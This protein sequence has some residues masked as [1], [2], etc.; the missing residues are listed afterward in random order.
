MKFFDNFKIFLTLLF[1]T[2]NSYSMSFAINKNYL[3]YNLIYASG[4]IRSGDLNRLKNIYYSLNRTKQT[5]VI[6]NSSGG[7]LYEGLNIGRFIKSNHIG[8]AVRK[9][10]ICASSCALAFFAG[11][12]KNGNRLNILPYTSYLGLHSFYYK[13]GKYVK[14]TKVQQDLSNILSYSSYVGIP[15]YLIAKMF[16]KKYNQMYWINS[17]DRVALNL[18][19]AISNKHYIK[20]YKYNY[21]RVS[22]EQYLKQYFSRI[23]NMINSNKDSSFCSSNIAL[24][25]LRYKTW[26]SQ[27]IKYI[28]LKNIKKINKKEVEAKVIYALKSGKRLC[29]INIYKLNKTRNSYNLIKKEYKNCNSTTINELKR[30]AKALP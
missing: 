10:G 26:I 6:F 20:H 9:N 15:Q 22:P 14:L 21:T 28:S 29:S 1:L 12:D 11:R 7:E 3:G 16:K 17:Q 19:S 5:I 25:T 18:K 13:N 30:L 23:N 8:T 27:N 24:S 4:H 2:L